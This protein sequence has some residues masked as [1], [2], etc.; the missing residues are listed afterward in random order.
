MRLSHPTNNIANSTKTARDF[1]AIDASPPTLSRY[2]DD[3]RVIAWYLEL[4]K[5]SHHHHHA[6]GLRMRCRAAQPP[7][8]QRAVV[9]PL[10]LRAA[11]G[12]S[13]EDFTLIPDSQ[14]LHPGNS[15]GGAPDQASNDSLPSPSWDSSHAATPHQCHPRPQPAV[16]FQE[17]PTSARAPAGFPRPLRLQTGALA[18]TVLNPEALRAH[19][20]ELRVGSRALRWDYGVPGPPGLI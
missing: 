20:V 6:C 12:I 8:V 9:P 15:R 18:V 3:L 13:P 16:L 10:H 7:S 11:W 19:W 2:R 17:Q 5:D 14:I 1:H 4:Q